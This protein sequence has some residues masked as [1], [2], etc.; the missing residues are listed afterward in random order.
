[1]NADHIDTVIVHI[2]R[3]LNNNSL[4]EVHRGMLD[5]G[6]TEDEA[7]LLIKAAQI[8]QADRSAAPPIKSLVRRVV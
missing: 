6:F 8:I 1:M 5:T 2:A 3:F 4:E 7:F